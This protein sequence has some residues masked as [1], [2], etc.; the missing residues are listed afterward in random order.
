[1]SLSFT[2]LVERKI[3]AKREEKAAARAAQQ[4]DNDKE[5]YKNFIARKVRLTEPLIDQ[6]VWH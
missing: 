2:S 1:M 6:P 3:K 5:A 4:A